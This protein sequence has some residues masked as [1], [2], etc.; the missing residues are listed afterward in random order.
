MNI[1]KQPIRDKWTEYT[2]ENDHG[3]SVSILNYGGIITKIMAPDRAGNIENVV[4]GYRDY[5]DYEANPN[6]FGAIIGRVAG[7]IQGASFEL[8]DDTYN[9]E[10][11][12]GDHHLHG[13]SNGFHSVI[14]KVEP[15]QNNGAVG[16]KL[17]HTSRDSDS[18]YPGNVDVSV[19]YTLLSNNDLILDYEASTDETTPLTLTN[20]SYFNLNGD[21]KATVDQH[22]VT[23]DSDKIIELDDELIPTGNG[24]K[25]AGTTFDFRKGRLLGDGFHDQLK[26]HAIAGSGYDHYFLFADKGKVV[27]REQQSGRMM[28]VKTNQPGMV[29]YTG[30]GLDDQSQLREG[31]SAKHLGVCFETQGTPAS[32]KHDFPSIMLQQGEMYKKRTVFSF[33]VFT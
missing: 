25:T 19:T 31:V 23:F 15:F 8:D 4:L 6:F 33:D 32:L 14:W 7:R 21:L 27:V 1:S 12:E 18:N 3:M 17:S 24:L 13:G 29:M 26:Q 2:L 9:L 22:H 10:K 30:N 28:T 20:H 16:L 5:A 11:N